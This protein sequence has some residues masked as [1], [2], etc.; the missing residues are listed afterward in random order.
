MRRHSSVPGSSSFTATPPRVTIA[1]FQP[2]VPVTC[3]GTSAQA[4]TVPLRPD[5]AEFRDLYKELIETNT[6]LS[7][8][9]CTLAAQ[10]M[11]KRFQAAEFP[12]D[13][14]ILHAALDRARAGIYRFNCKAMVGEEVACEAA[15]MCTMRDVA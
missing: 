1:R 9:S 6:T 8:G 10:R 15:I 3:S 12:G 11:L 4:Q 5:Q 14:L 13:Q 2:S 7:S